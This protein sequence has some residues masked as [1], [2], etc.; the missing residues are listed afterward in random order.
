MEILVLG[1]RQ[2]TDE[3]LLKIPDGHKV[4]VGVNLDPQHLARFQVVFDLN[5]D[6][7]PGHLEYYSPKNELIVFAGAVKRQL[8]Q[9]ISEFKGDINNTSIVAAR[10]QYF[11]IKYC[12]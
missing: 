2:R 4:V 7:N 5:F 8:A 1:D 12:G 10:I 9:V 11:Q 6:N 3:L